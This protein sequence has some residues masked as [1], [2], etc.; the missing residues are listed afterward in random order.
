MP[1][2]LQRTKHFIGSAFGVSTTSFTGDSV[3]FQG[4]GQGHGAGPTGWAVASAPIINMLCTAGYGA[5]FVTALSCA[6]LSFV[7][8]AFVDN[9]DLVHTRP[10]DDVEG[11]ELIPEMQ[12]VVD[13]WEGGLR[14]TGGALVPSRLRAIGI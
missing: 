3:P 12:E 2:T 13:H 5:T 6:V 9:T 10:G 7:C 8:Y 1:T 14:A 11:V 4:L